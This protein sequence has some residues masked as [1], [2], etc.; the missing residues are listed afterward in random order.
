MC[1][2]CKVVE[3]YQKNARLQGALL[4][5]MICTGNIQNPLIIPIPSKVIE[6]LL[7]FFQFSFNTYVFDYFVFSSLVLSSALR[8]IPQAERFYE[9]L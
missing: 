9:T 1:A 5:Q 6:I 7:K 4:L 2:Q 8:G 3:H